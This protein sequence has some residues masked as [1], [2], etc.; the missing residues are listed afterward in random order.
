MVQRRWSLLLHLILSGVML[1][2]AAV[3]LILSIAAAST[4]DEGVL[5][6]CYTAMHVLAGTSVR[7][8]TIGA[9]V[10]GILLSVLTQWGFFRFY[11]IIVKEGLTFLSIALG[12]VGMYFWTLRAVTL[13]SREGLGAL[14]DPSFHVNSGQLWTGIILQ[15]VSIAAM[16]AI[17]VF[18]PWGMRKP[19]HGPSPN[20][21]EG[22]S[23]IGQ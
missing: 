17:S 13:T 4:N 5:K 9:T 11:W 23:S 1:G 14:Q 7:A 21:K 18:K 20:G 10:T 8:S 22:R 15:T 19:K 16:F 12:P 2:G 6:A 3:F